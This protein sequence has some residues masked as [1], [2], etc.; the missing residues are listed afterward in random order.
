MH[1]FVFCLKYRFNF[2]VTLLDEKKSKKK[3]AC[4]CCRWSPVFYMCTKNKKNQG[5]RYQLTKL[6]PQQVAH[7][8]CWKKFFESFG[9]FKDHYTPMYVIPPVD[10]I[11]GKKSISL[12]INIIEMH[13]C[14]VFSLTCT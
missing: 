1:D 4:N 8:K 9:T 6:C 13:D 12:N 5:Q 7:S 3:N 2:S 14:I 11:Q 10:G